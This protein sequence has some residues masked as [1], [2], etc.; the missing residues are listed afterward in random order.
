MSTDQYCSI[1][2]RDSIDSTPLHNPNIQLIS[3][4]KFSGW[5]SL[6]K[7]DTTSYGIDDV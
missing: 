1:V 4:M 5:L 6:T 2:C 7:N 3:D